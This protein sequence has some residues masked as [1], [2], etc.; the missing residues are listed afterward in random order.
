MAKMNNVQMA[1]D[2]ARLARDIWAPRASSTSTRSSG[3]C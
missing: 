2:C 1:L 3:T